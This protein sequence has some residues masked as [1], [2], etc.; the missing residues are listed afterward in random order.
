MSHTSQ[1]SPFNSLHAYRREIIRLREDP[2]K[3]PLHNIDRRSCWA[4]CLSLSLFMVYA[5]L[6]VYKAGEGAMLF[7]CRCCLLL[8]IYLRDDRYHSHNNGI[9]AASLYHN[10]TVTATPDCF[11][12]GACH[13]HSHAACLPAYAKATFSGSLFSKCYMPLFPCH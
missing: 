13:W 4:T 6:K 3:M 10:I 12:R 5:R 8:G 7:P 2:E 11:G 9:I 1:P